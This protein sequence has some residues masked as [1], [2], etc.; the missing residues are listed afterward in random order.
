MREQLV[1]LTNLFENHIKTEAVHPRGPS[2]S[3]N[4]QVP[5]PLIQTASHLPH[6][7]DCPNLRQPMPTTPPA[8]MATSRPV[9]QPNDSKVK[10][11]RQKTGK[12]KTQ[13][14]PIPI[15]YTE[16]LPNLIESGFIQPF[17]LAPLRPPFSRWYN[18][19]V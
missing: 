5:R 10:Y 4:Q 15:T 9:N 2:L 17:Y 14:D 7:T 12:D 1:R 16:L 6:G 8:F 18:A 3:P 13:W 19:N 11:S